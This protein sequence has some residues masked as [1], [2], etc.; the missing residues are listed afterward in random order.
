MQ[1]FNADCGCAVAWQIFVCLVHLCGVVRS[2]R[3]VCAPKAF[4]KGSA[5]IARCI[6]LLL[7]DESRLI[8]VDRKVGEESTRKNEAVLRWTLS[9]RV[10][11]DAS[12]Y[13]LAEEHTLSVASQ[14]STNER[15]KRK[16]WCDQNVFAGHRT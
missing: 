5:Y 15:L 3:S 2:A 10:N 1:I 14:L 8:W 6:I 16:F 4:R 9:W 7:T 12:C 11:C 13:N